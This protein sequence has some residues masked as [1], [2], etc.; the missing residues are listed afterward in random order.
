[1]HSHLCRRQ[2]NAEHLGDVAHWKLLDVSEHNGQPLVGIES[3]QCV[4]K[5]DRDATQ[6]GALLGTE[7]RRCGLGHVLGR[8]RLLA[9][10]SD[11]R[12]RF[13]ICHLQQ[14]RPDLGIIIQL[15]ESSE[16]FDEGCLDY[17]F[18]VRTIPQH[19]IRNVE[20]RIDM[21]YKESGHPVGQL[22]VEV[23]IGVVHLDQLYRF[24]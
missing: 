18:S 15:I 9:T 23:M 2:P 1:M 7:V 16:R 24:A 5:L 11:R 10:P 19:A 17:I 4:R 3:R 20:D 6:H 14:P 8:E 22:L 13:S 21:S 12:D